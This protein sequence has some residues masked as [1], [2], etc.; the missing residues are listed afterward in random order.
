M[1]LAASGVVVLTLS[2]GI[3]ERE[4]VLSPVIL[5]GVVV[6]LLAMLGVSTLFFNRWVRRVDRHIR[7]LRRMADPNCKDAEGGAA[8]LD[9]KDLERAT[10]ALADAIRR[11]LSAR[12]AAMA[13]MAAFQASD[14]PGLICDARG[15]VLDSNAALAH[16][17]SE[18]PAPGG[19]HPNTETPLQAFARNAMIDV[20]GARLPACRVMRVA[21]KLAEVSVRRADDSEDRVLYLVEVIR[22]EDQRIAEAISQSLG[23][24]KLRADFDDAGRGVHMN[25]AFMAC[26]STPTGTLLSLDD[27]ALDGTG[28]SPRQVV[29]QGAPVTARVHLPADR[30]GKTLDGTFVPVTGKDGT[31][32]RIIFLG[33]DVTDRLRVESE[34]RKQEDMRKARG[35]AED[36][37][38]LEG[39]ARLAAGEFESHLAT[40]FQEERD[41]LRLA[42]NDAVSALRLAEREERLRVEAL[43]QEAALR[44][45]E[46]QKAVIAAEAQMK[47]LD[48]AIGFF[49]GASAAQADALNAAQKARTALAGASEVSRTSGTA[50]ERTKDTMAGIENSSAQINGL[51]GT[52]Q[53]I[54]LQTN[55][56]ALN[57]GIE[58]ARAG[59]SGRGFAVVASEV[60][61]LAQRSSE[62]A[63]DISGIIETSN[64]QI[65]EGVAMVEQAG[66]SL[67]GLALSIDAIEEDL[68]SAVI[69][70]ETQSRPH[71]QLSNALKDLTEMFTELAGGEG[72]QMLPT[73]LATSTPVQA[74]SNPGTGEPDRQDAPNAT[75][76]FV[77]SR[78]HATNLSAPEAPQPRA[79]EDRGP[80]TLVVA[81]DRDAH[82][83]TRA[84]TG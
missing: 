33:E 2:R 63:R 75:P 71:Q 22:R 82:G 5:H 52:L 29:M 6:G 47:T 20:A 54:A 49:S 72:S 43:Q 35:K 81:Y 40:P 9:L 74:S 3:V 58:A 67:S 39:L 19:Q 70:M 65:S 23:H 51:L 18:D 8:H 76:R 77:S 79:V 84:S 69:A 13:R 45:T 34:A 38:L 32:T 48:A 17:L 27:F 61:A 44:K 59:A 53:K 66:N 60:R 55:L 56:L 7:H 36:A 30:G 4:S 50:V 68:S 31:T 16:M 10:E 28:H 11:C 57:A 21:G 80:G 62:A 46:Q 42:F 14:T 24:A 73:P 15:K 41:P 1:L 64:A 26:L 83:D 37:T 25:A 12:D 78:K